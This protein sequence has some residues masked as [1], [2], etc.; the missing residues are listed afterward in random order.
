MQRINTLSSVEAPADES[1]DEADRRADHH[2]ETDRGST[3]EQRDARPVNDPAELVSTV[4]VESHQVLDL[5]LVTAEQVDAWS[6]EPDLVG[7]RI[8]QH[9]GW[10]I[11]SDERGEHGHADDQHGEGE[12]DAAGPRV[13]D[14]REHVAPT[15]RGRDRHVRMV[16]AR[17]RC[18]ELCRT[19]NDVEV[20]CHENSAP[21][22][23]T[24]RQPRSGQ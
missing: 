2:G 15:A 20:G 23:A 18:D 19:G 12:A 11:G 24:R 21:M 10:A 9:L 1:G 14:L 13:D 8:E 16:R 4:L 3:G 5:G 6:F 22:R 17:C 7:R